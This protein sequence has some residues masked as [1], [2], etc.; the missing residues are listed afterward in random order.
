MFSGIGPKDQLSAHN[1]EVIVESPHVG[2]NLLDHPVLP[3]VFQLKDSYG[4]DGHLLR[5]GSMN[6]A[7]IAAYRKDRKGLYHSGLLELVGFPRTDDNFMTSQE[8]VE[9]KK[10]SQGINPFGPAG[11]PH[12]E[13]DFVVRWPF[14]PTKYAY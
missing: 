4:L 7:A 2:Q 9:A 11:Q 14:P 10:Q 5:A 3:H 8:Y 6:D 13:I 1:I 12:F